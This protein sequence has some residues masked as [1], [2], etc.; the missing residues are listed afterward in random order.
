MHWLRVPERMK[1]RLVVF[2]CR[3]PIALEYLA[4][5]LQWA[6]EVE[7]QRRMRSAS[8][9]RLVIRRTQ[10]RTVGDRTF[11]AAVPRLWNSL[12]ADV[13]ATQSLATFKGRLKTFLFEQPFD[14]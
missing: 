1:F 4:T 2:C 10:L 11:S 5:E 6:V 9:Q 13:V 3:N 7:S 14:H 8:S 12:P